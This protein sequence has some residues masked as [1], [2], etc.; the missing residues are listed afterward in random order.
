MR[1]ACFVFVVLAAACGPDAPGP[2]WTEP[3]QPTPAPPGAPPPLHVEGATLRDEA[4]REVRLRGVNVCALE[5]DAAGTHWQLQ[6]DGGSPVLDALA[7]R[8]RWAA[9]VVRMPVNQEWFLTDEAYVARV[10]ALVD[11]AAVRGLYVLLDVQ[12]ERA[13]RTEPYHLN[14]LRV[15]TFGAGN[16]TEAFWHRASSRFANRPHVLYDLVNEPHDTPAEEVSAAMQRLVDRLRTRSAAPVLVIG[17]PDWA[18][19][20][21]WYRE[22]PLRG[23]NL[24]YSAHQYLPYDGVDQ[25][26]ENFERTA[27]AAPVLL[28]EFSAERAEVDGRAWQAVLV[29]RAEAAG[30]DGWLPWAI[31]CGFTV[32]DDRSGPPHLQALAA[33]M[34]A[35]R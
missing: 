18:H 9:N 27:E 8:T 21:A 14:I 12:W 19:S 11:A 3:V 29:E 34:R 32:D 5:F 7:D 31:G 6:P 16:T 22:H 23:G 35:L 25:F 1:R 17:G 33:T 4:G 28:G 15:P 13:Q 10:E 2:D 20:V 24:V 26:A 30:V